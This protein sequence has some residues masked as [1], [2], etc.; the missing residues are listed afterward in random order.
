MTDI[1]IYIPSFIGGLLIGL[2][3]FG[4]LRWITAQIAEVE[5]PSRLLL[6]SFLVRTPLALIAFYWVAND[7]WQGLILALIG[8]VLARMILVRTLSFT[9]TEYSREVNPQHGT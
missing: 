5:S 7:S 6:G 4:S 2:A 1:L 9:E 3:Y 8:F